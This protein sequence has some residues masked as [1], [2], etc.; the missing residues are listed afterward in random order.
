MVWLIAV[1][2]CPAQRA[3]GNQIES[4][5]RGEWNKGSRL[6]KLGFCETWG[7]MDAVAE[8]PSRLC[9][10]CIAFCLR[11]A[12][13]DF[14]RSRS[15][16]QRFRLYLQCRG[17]V[18]TVSIFFS[19][20]RDHCWSE[21]RTILSGTQQQLSFALPARA[22]DVDMGSDSAQ[23]AAPPVPPRLYCKLQNAPIVGQ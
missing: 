1:P 8:T 16:C 6:P 3:Y 18:C 22:D 10:A 9:H 14:H 21:T 23:P 7:S 5:R 19:L 4:I 13:L 12:T 2:P 20:M 15:L 11:T 17:I